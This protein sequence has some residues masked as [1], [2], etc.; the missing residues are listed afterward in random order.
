MIRTGLVSITFRQLSPEAIIDLVAQ[1][2]LEGIE[3]GGDIHVPHG[4]VARARQVRQWTSDAGLVVP[5]YGSYYRVNASDLPF[6]AV[7]DS[8]VA[9]GAPIVR[10]WAGRIGSDQADRGYRQAVVAESRQIA[11]LAQQAGVAVAYEFHGNTL[12]DS[13]A[14]A[15]QLLHEVA[16]PNVKSY[17]QPMNSAPESDRLT[18]LRAVLPWLAHL[19]VFTWQDSAR[20]PLAD[21]TAL[22]HKR[23]EIIRTTGREHFAL[24]EFVQ[25]N[26]SH[27]FLR[28]AAALAKWTSDG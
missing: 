11:D 17:W 4:D 22:W 18:G 14:S 13:N 26:D 8:A 19:H 21:G 1:T 25:D 5:S 16:H 24:I 20:L 28:D 6:E 9:L 2:E 23:L 3:W 10:V 15:L 27:T 12:T 7:L